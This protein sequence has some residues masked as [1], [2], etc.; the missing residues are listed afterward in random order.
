MRVAI[1]TDTYSPDI[2]GVVTSVRIL[3]EELKKNKHEVYIVTSSNNTRIT[4][5]GNLIKLPGISIKKLYGYNL[6]GFYSRNVIQYLHNL[7]LNIIHAHTEYGVGIFAR[8]A[9]RQLDI[10]LVYTYHTMYEDY[11]HYVT[12]Y[13]NGHFE[14]PLKKLIDTG[15]K[16]Y[17]DN[18]T[19]LIVPSF[20]TA[21]ALLRYGVNNTINVIPTGI[22][23]SKFKKDLYTE[24]QLQEVRNA[25]NIKKDDF[26]VIN[27]GRIAPEKNTDEIVKA[28]IE[29]KKQNINNVKLLIVGDGPSLETIKKMIVD[30]KL[31]EIVYTVGK[32]VHEKVAMMYQCANV[33]VSTSTSETQGLTFIEAMASG[34]PVI[35]RYDKNLE[36]LVIEDK[37][38]YYIDSYNELA[39][40]ILQLSN[41]DKQTYEKLVE[42]ALN[43]STEYSS[44]LFYKQ[45]MVVYNNAIR[46]LRSKKIK[47]NNIQNKIAI[48][49]KK[50]L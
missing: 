3:E 41:I 18:T 23:L 13:T 37:T 25:Y 30:N 16:F 24:E 50:I 33:F 34:L 11:T 36:S 26:V 10:P 49:N 12:K 32:V 17:A 5:E 45:I 31:E 39:S 1:F 35:C 38:G 43:K 29:I 8:I 28:F 2:N 27:I 20:K 46:N 47:N 48:K 6:S 19:E 14:K 42:N 22:D 40:K 9:A 44:E 4:R 15:T 21:D 7:D